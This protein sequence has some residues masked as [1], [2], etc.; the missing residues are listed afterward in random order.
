MEDTE[1][2]TSYM[3]S[4]WEPHAHY[5]PD[6]M[7]PLADITF[8]PISGTPNDCILFIDISSSMM[9]L[10]QEPYN[11]CVQ[12]LQTLYDSAVAETDDAIR[13]KLLNVNVRVIEFNDT[14]TTIVNTTVQHLNNI[15]FSYKPCGLTDLY[16][17]IYSILTE[18]PYKPKDLVIVSDGENNTGPF[19]SNYI[20]RQLTNAMELG[21]SVKFVG[22]TLEA[23]TESER[24]NLT[25]FS[26]NCSDGE[27]TIGSVMRGISEE[28]SQL[29][30]DRFNA[31]YFGDEI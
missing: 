21:W 13:E 31:Y 3:Y 8:T 25:R 30:R 26:Y 6:I 29:N 24:L 19:H 28:Q 18:T 11:A 15:S 5:N 14:F 12:Y 2:Q 27:T 16:S 17:P 7:F 23:L 4:R 9:L 1:S 22:C 10:G 20:S